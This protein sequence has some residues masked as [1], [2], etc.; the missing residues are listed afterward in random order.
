[1]A[2]E[3]WGVIALAELLVLGAQLDDLL[4]GL[5]IEL[6]GRRQLADSDVD[7]WIAALVSREPGLV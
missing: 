7:R 5:S 1:M 3:P 4:L 6:L 2:P